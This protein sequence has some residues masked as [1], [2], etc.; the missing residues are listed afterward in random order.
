MKRPLTYGDVLPAIHRWMDRRAAQV[1]R[2][3]LSASAL[4]YINLV[5]HPTKGTDPMSYPTSITLSIQEI[6]NGVI[7]T[8]EANDTAYSIVGVMAA[9][10][11]FHSIDDAAMALA[12][13]ARD[14]WDRAKQEAERPALRVQSFYADGG[15]NPDKLPEEAAVNAE[16]IPVVDEGERDSAFLRTD[17]V[18][19][20][21]QAETF[22]V[23]SEAPQAER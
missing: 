23:D 12:G 2:N 20:V 15:K 7:V 1:G 21:G 17:P 19:S 4:D 3:Y 16:P 5:D 18:M 13:V 6:S 11:F 10:T 8:S 9:G 22:D 14:A